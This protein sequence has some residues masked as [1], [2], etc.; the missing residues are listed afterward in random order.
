VSQQCLLAGLPRS[1]YYYVPIAGE[2]A[3]NLKLM[4]S[5]DRIYMDY[6][7]FGSPRITEVLRRQG[8]QVNVKRVARL[9]RVM[10]LQARL[11]GPHTSR[12][13]PEH[14]VYP[15]LLK[16]LEIKAP[17]VVWSADITYVPLRHGYMY[18]LA[19]LDWFSRFVL[20]WEISNTMETAFCVETLERA[21][22]QYGSPSIFNTDQG[23][24]FTS[25]EFTGRLN[26]T[27]I[28][29]SMDGRGRALDNVF[30]ERLWRT[31]KYEDIYL[32]D[33]ADGGELRQGL[34]NYFQFYRSRRPHQ[35]L[36]YR[37]P[38]EVHF[39]RKACA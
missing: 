11:P 32:H 35:A 1:T 23:A 13:H 16:G 39:E 36:G 25:E 12:P 7:F 9:M 34:T 2:T 37:T 4:R 24:Q 17:N 3:E 19:I 6:P 29:I 21:L 30:V 20:A 5:I 14:R 27:G 33:Y 28:R 15:Y 10:G 22:T 38:E 26:A 31:V 18:L 8:E